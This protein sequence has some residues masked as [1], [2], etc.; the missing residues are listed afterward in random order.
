MKNRNDKDMTI[1]EIR[2]DFPI[3]K[4]QIN[5][6]PLIY[7]D[8][9][10]TAQ[11]PKQ[12][13]DS[14]TDYYTNYNSNIHRGVHELS[15]RATEKYEEAREK[16]RGF[17]NANLVEE[18]IF[19]SGTTDSINLVAQTFSEAFLN[20]GDEIIISEME[21]HSN[22]V[23]WQMA[24]ERT[25][26]KLKVIPI[27]QK[28]ELI[29]EE[30]EKLLSDQTKIV[31][32]TH[33]SNTLGTINPVKDIMEKAHALN[34]PVLLDGAQSVPHMKIDVQDLDCEFYAFSGHKMF[35]PTG[36]GILYGKKEWLEKIPPY[37]G[38]GDMIK[39][40]TFEKTTYNILPHKME[41]GT[42][43]IVGGIALGSAIDYMNKV[44]FD[45]IQKQEEEL[46][47]YATE[48]VQEIEGLKI[49]GTA[50]K[51]AGVLSFVVEGTHPFDLG[52]ILDQQGV[53]VRTGH[54]CTQPIMDF[55]SIPGTAR[56]S[57]AFYNTKEEVDFFV[58]ALKRAVRM[59]V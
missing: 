20:E 23:P 44:G 57:F 8:N 31:A 34:I 12:V 29:I 41:A 6:K 11:K 30:F 22:I 16:V 48:K 10:A 51:K 24:C 17:I 32:I 58:E 18:I 55:F 33:V 49:I 45:F 52:T 25:G 5:G 38:G 42:P 13:I 46:L 7:F 14:I 53:A 59:L 54:H 19:T 3:L 36:V 56:A 40:V 50:S 37:K 35:G 27:N 4:Q 47:S 15:Q 2:N 28:G 39:E 21:H 26:A 43:N 9:G 1:D